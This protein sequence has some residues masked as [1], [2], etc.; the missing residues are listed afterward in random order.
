MMFSSHLRSILNFDCEMFWSQI[1]I[2]VY[3]QR[4]PQA[5]ITIATLP[6]KPERLLMVV[7]RINT[8][9][10]RS[11]NKRD[12]AWYTTRMMKMEKL[13]RDFQAHH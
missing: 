6:D 1:H 10:A 2:N 8:H 3:Q 7:Y 12:F 13:D 5:I 9:I 11:W 4:L